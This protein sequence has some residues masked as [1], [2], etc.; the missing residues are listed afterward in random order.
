ME[1]GKKWLLSKENIN[2]SSYSTWRVGGRADFFV[3]PQN[4]E[5]IKW[6][7]TQSKSQKW[8]VTIIGGGTNCLISDDGLKGL[9]ISL[10]KLVSITSSIEDDFLKIECLAGTSKILLMKEFLKHQLAPA[11]F[12]SGIPGCVGG[13]IVMNAGVSEDI[14]P[15]QFSQIVDWVDVIYNNHIVRKKHSDIKWSYRS[16]K[17]WQPGIIAR[18]GL[19]WPLEPIEHLSQ[20]VKHARDIRLSKQP[21]KEASCGSTFINP[22]SHTHFSAGELIE[23]SGLKGFQIGQA[24]VSEKHANFIVNL[25]RAK[26][27][28][29]HNIISYV[30]RSVYDKM[31]IHLQTEVKYLGL[32]H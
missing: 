31:G 5:D 1:E 27:Q 15:Y 30:Q 28:D 19:K 18:V 21:L 7:E 32:F 25:G 29:I 17:G 14:M 11:I 20:K 3:E 9:V 2:L 4:I 22:K 10:K 6:I 24:K 13:G 16:S 8:P 12:L 23:Q 26:A